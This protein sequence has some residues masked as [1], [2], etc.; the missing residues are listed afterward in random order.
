MDEFISTQH[1]GIIICDRYL[2]STLAYCWPYS[3]EMPN[4]IHAIFPN[5]R[6]P[7]YTFYLDAPLDVRAQRIETRRR[8]GLPLT[9]GDTNIIQQNAAESRYRKFSDMR[10]IDTSTLSPQQV[11]AKIRQSLP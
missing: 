4:D 10:L 8:E 1:N 9:P 7:D 5:L 2:H 3:Y 6:I 11:V